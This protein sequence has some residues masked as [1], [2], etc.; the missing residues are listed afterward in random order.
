MVNDQAKKKDAIQSL[1]SRSGCSG[2]IGSLIA[3]VLDFFR[4]SY[5]ALAT[6][7]YQYES[8][9][10][11]LGWPLL[12]INLGFDSSTGKMRQAK[13][14]IAIGTRATGILSFGFFISR[15]IVAIGGIAFGLGTVSL[16]S[17]AIISVTVFGLD[18]VSVSFFAVGYLAVGVLALG[19]KS[20]GIPA[21]GKEV[22][23]II[24]AGRQVNSLFPP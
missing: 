15:G 5:R 16:F 3:A 20:V 6:L 4:Q 21:I 24:C 10:R 17:I 12:S 18:F 22:V 9:Q 1:A 8:R 23:G 11:F 19:Y 7:N 13:G 2:T 14:F